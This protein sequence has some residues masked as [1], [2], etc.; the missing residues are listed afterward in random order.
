MNLVIFIAKFGRFFQQKLNKYRISIYIT[1]NLFFYLPE[2]KNVENTFIIRIDRNFYT[3][4]SEFDL[5]AL[6][7]FNRPVSLKIF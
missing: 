1:N 2:N 3:V 5:L 7:P 4:F 6:A